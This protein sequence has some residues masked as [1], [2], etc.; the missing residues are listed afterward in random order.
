MMESAARMRK[1]EMKCWRK[2][3]QGVPVW[4]G[5]L[6]PVKDL[7]ETN[8]NSWYKFLLKLKLEEA[9]ML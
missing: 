5:K 2:Y 6:T 9:T 1:T 3:K 8:T 7:I 4:S